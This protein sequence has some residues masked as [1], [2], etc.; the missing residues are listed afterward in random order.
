MNTKNVEKLVQVIQDLV[1]EEK[2][3]DEAMR[4]MRPT[5]LKIIDDLADHE[6]VELI[7]EDEKLSKE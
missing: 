3:S 4:R 7:H 6:L 5:L 1:A 2:I